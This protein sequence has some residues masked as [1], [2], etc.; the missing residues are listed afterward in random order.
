MSDAGYR[1]A[2]ELIDGAE[3]ADFVGPRPEE[4]VAA[5]E[6]AL[7]LEFPPD[8]RRFVLDLGAGDVGG[9]EFF[10]VVDDDFEDA[11]IPDGVWLTLRERQDSGLPG[12]LILVHAPGDGS[13]HAIEPGGI[14]VR[15]VPGEA[16][17]DLVA[18][19]FG[20]FLRRTVEDALG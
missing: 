7:G 18:S 10:G 17:R 15:W 3:D 19:G 16:R 6:R 13:Y 12:D 5:A 9:E 2:R 20:E 4:L 14:V 8:Y 11:A 1:A